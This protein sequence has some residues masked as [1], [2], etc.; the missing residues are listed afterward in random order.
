MIDFNKDSSDEAQIDF[1]YRVEEKAM[2]LIAA[3]NING[4]AEFIEEF[5]DFE[6]HSSKFTLLVYRIPTDPLRDRKNGLVI[7]N[8]FCRIAA[9]NGGLPPLYLHHI[10]E[11]YALMIERA[12]SIDYI[13]NKLANSMFMEYVEAVNK[14]ST[15]AYSKLIK[16]IVS[17]IAQNLTN[18]LTLSDLSKMFHVHPA[19]LSRKFKQET[20]MTVME[21]I[22]YHRINHAKLLFQEG[23]TNILEVAALS[24]FNSSS[25]FDKVFKKVTNQTPSHYLKENRLKS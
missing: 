1:R 8:T 23:K 20:G 10:S 17:Y 25:Y 15:S 5:N 21:Y 4:M 13:K 19:H 3:G 14:F 2:N 18:E 16:D 6:K 9:R 12:D 7:R 11:K 22:Q 24:G